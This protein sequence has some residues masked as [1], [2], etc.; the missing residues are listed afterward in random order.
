MRKRLY[1]ILILALTLSSCGQKLESLEKETDANNKEDFIYF[2]QQDINSNQKKYKDAG[3]VKIN[4]PF[5]SYIRNSFLNGDLENFS[6]DLHSKI[7]SYTNRERFI[8]NLFIV[9]FTYKNEENSLI[10][11]N[12]LLI[13]KPKK[14]GKKLED[15][16]AIEIISLYKF[17]SDDARETTNKF[18]FLSEK[19]LEKMIEKAL[20]NER[21]KEEV[22]NIVPIDIRNYQSLA[23]YFVKNKDEIKELEN[24]KLKDKNLK[25]NLRIIRAKFLEEKLKN[26]NFNSEIQDKIFILFRENKLENYKIISMRDIQENEF[27]E[28]ILYKK[29][30][31]SDSLD[32][33][34]DIIKN[35]EN[36]EDVE[37]IKILSTKVEDNE[38]IV[39]TIDDPYNPINKYKNDFTIEE[40]KKNLKVVVVEYEKTLKEKISTPYSTNKGKKV[41]NYRQ[42]I[43][44][45]ENPKTKKIEFNSVSSKHY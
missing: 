25:E 39:S 28:D 15:K 14:I 27:F 3:K 16:E 9:S 32:L 2:V 37:S 1:L 6:R 4:Y 34:K 42:A 33:A 12:H 11:A 21:F 36:L 23:N 45:F 22:I 18:L 7:D 44:V 29:D 41:L 35:R 24:L 10:T 30:G 13:E 38:N 5:T 8:N 31:Y 43:Y 26:G 17:D 19:N 40:I 20:V